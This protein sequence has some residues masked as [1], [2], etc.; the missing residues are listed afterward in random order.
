MGGS[1]APIL[2]GVYNI[3]YEISN[4]AL[5]ELVAPIQRALLPGYSRLS[6]D[7][8]KL[9]TA[10]ID[11]LGLA[12]LFG[13]PVSAGISVTAD[14]VVP[15]L[16]GDK[17]SDAIPLIQLLAVA[18]LFRIGS[19]NSSVVYHA[20]GKPHIITF[21]TL[22][23]VAIG[24][25]LLYFGTVTWGAVGATGSVVL[26]SAMF[27]TANIMVVM[28]LLS[29]NFSDIWAVGWRASISTMTMVVSVL[30]ARSAMWTS[31]HSFLALVAELVVSVA[32]GA[33][34][35]V[36]VTIGVWLL[37]GKP[38]SAEQIVLD[39]LSKRFPRFLPRS[40]S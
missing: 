34:S 11:V 38:K 17:W 21:M 31:S 33:I 1:L 6:S 37:C 18:G 7:L 19:A 36:V 24:L 32:V 8:D 20:L 15:V 22:V 39:E 13:L 23:A 2:R 28:R 14:L 4:L 30:L 40:R 35:F 25:P 27:M 12:L 9:R 26:V 16:L 3:A 29:L 5:T 10:Y